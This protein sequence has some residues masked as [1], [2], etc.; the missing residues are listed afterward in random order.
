MPLSTITEVI[1]VII[2]GSISSYMYVLLP[3]YCS[4]IRNGMNDEVFCAGTFPVCN[5]NIPHQG[6]T[7][8]ALSISTGQYF[9]V[10]YLSRKSYYS[11]ESI[12]S[13]VI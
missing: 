12:I 8:S 9:I 11:S 5:D 7:I 3:E 13:D 6:V 4:V 2:Y 10:Q 1:R